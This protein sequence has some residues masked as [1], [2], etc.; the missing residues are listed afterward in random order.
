MY[1]FGWVNEEQE[2]VQSGVRLPGM[3]SWMVYGDTK[4]PVTGLVAF[5]AEDRPPVKMVFQTASLDGRNR[6]GPHRALAWLGVPARRKC[7]LR[8]TAGVMDLPKT[9][10]RRRARPASAS[11]GGWV[12][13]EVG[14]QPWI[15]YGLLRTAKAFA[16][17]SRPR[18][19]ALSRPV[20][21]IYLL[22]FAPFLFLL[23]HK[24]TQGPLAEDLSRRHSASLTYGHSISTRFGFSWSAFSCRYAVLDGFDLGMASSICS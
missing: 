1:L 4:K 2:K 24:I 20:Y 11:S 21:L 8:L 17:R 7:A 23:N 5:A 6:H 10:V 13:A 18:L 9:L 19:L 12:T 22:L 14:R 15:V 3:L 16:G